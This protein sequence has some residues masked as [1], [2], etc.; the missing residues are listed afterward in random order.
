[1]K[2]PKQAPPVC[3]SHHTNRYVPIPETTD[4]A[5]AVA[6]ALERWDD[7]FWTPDSGEDGRASIEELPD[8][9]VALIP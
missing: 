5:R 1:M 4:E 9:V 7:E 2:P 8:Y 6:G 3:C